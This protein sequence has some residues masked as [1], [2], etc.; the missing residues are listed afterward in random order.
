MKETGGGSW[1]IIENRDGISRIRLGESL[2]TPLQVGGKEITIF[3]FV[4]CIPR[5]RSPFKGTILRIRSRRKVMGML[6]LSFQPG[7]VKDD[8]RFWLCDMME[9][10]WSNGNSKESSYHLCEKSTRFWEENG[11]ERS[12]GGRY[13]GA[14]CASTFLRGTRAK[15]CS[16]SGGINGGRGK[17]GEKKICSIVAPLRCIYE[18]H[19]EKFIRQR[20]EFPRVG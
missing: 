5:T 3:F 13:F 6:P 7:I 18:K 10:I 8:K 14:L 9:N 12:L 11:E 4:P 15:T 17:K 20:G 2:Y 19:F 1:R 16:L